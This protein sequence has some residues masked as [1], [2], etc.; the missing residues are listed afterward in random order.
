MELQIAEKLSNNGIKRKKFS[1]ILIDLLHLLHLLLCQKIYHCFNWKMENTVKTTLLRLISFRP[2]KIDWCSFLLCTIPRS[3]GQR[4]LMELSKQVFPFPLLL[5]S[6][7]CFWLPWG[8][9]SYALIFTFAF[10]SLVLS[11]SL[12]EL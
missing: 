12:F 5:L 11:S 4:A 9:C 6:N 10:S 1:T 3:R 8:L 7:F 2:W